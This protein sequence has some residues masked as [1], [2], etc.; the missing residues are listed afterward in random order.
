MRASDCDVRIRPSASVPRT[1]GALLSRKNG[2]IS[3]GNDLAAPRKSNTVQRGPVVPGMR[4]ESPP[5]GKRV[6]ARS[7]SPVYHDETPTLYHMVARR[8]LALETMRR[9]PSRA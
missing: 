7:Y 8:E 4:V 9:K 2:M 1:Y 6:V 3:R 5:S